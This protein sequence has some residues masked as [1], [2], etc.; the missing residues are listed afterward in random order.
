MIYPVLLRRKLFFDLLANDKIF[1]L[2]DTDSQI[3]HFLIYAGATR[4]PV[5]QTIKKKDTY[6]IELMMLSAPQS[7]H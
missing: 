4:I 6:L 5:P 1:G 2:K 3:Q 7:Q